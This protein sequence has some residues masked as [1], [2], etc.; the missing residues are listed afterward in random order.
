[1]THR[2]RWQA[3]QAHLAAARAF[4]DAGDQQHALVEVRAA[5][6]LDPDFLAAQSLRDRIINKPAPPTP[7][8]APPM[9][10]KAAP[11]PP[12]RPTIAA[13][14]VAAPAAAATPLAASAVPIGESAPTARGDASVPPIA[15]LRS[16]DG[17]RASSSAA[18]TV[19]ANIADFELPLAGWHSARSAEAATAATG[20][21]D[22]ELR[23]TDSR[24]GVPATQSPAAIPAQAPQPPLVSTEG[25]ARFEARARRRRVDRRVEGA[26]SAIERKRLHEAAV[27]L[28][29]IIALDPNLPELTALTAEFDELRKAMASPHRGPW[30]IAVAVFAGVVLGASWLHESSLLVS[31]PVTG[32]MALISPPPKALADEPAAAEPAVATAGVEEVQPAIDD[33]EPPIAPRP[34]PSRPETVPAVLRTPVMNER[35]HPAPAAPAPGPVPDLAIPAIGEPSPPPAAAVSTPPPPAP[36]PVA[37]PPALRAAAVPAAAPVSAPSAPVPTVPAIP[38]S[39]GNDDENLVKQTLQRYRHAYEGL[40]ARS[41]HAVWPSVDQAALA[42]AFGGLTSQSITFDRCDVRLSGALAN[43]TCRGTARYVPKIGNREP[44][45]EP[46]VWSFALRKDGGEWKIDS[47]R[48]ER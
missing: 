35:E 19:G 18:P 37:A 40:D 2:E 33:A 22:L 7:G 31:Y 1:V 17:V 24:A 14:A 13:P 3:L 4:A 21:A 25:Y 8:A 27:A 39:P 5:L 10:F 9:K 20:L 42:R 32:G 30:L 12:A 43:A 47:A 15:R 34:R 41:A 11:L 6:A 36:P 23:S 16:A 48:A 45:V 38:G 26:R 29:E 44:R 28:D 46:R